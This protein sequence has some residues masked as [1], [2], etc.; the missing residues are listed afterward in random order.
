MSSSTQWQQGITL[1]LEV[2]NGQ[3]YF[4][5]SL[6]G[7]PVQALQMLIYTRLLGLQVLRA[8]FIVQLILLKISNQHQP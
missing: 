5:D 7:S 3:I 1:N 6:V 4:D 2:L 8:P